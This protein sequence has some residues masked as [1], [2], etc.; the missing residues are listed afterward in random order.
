MSLKVI[1]RAVS[2]VVLGVILVGPVRSFAATATTV[3]AHPATDI[4]ITEV[5]TSSLTNAGEE[6][7]ELYNNTTQDIDLAD[8]AHAGKDA[9]KLQYFSSSKLGTILGN[10]N[11]ASPFRTIALTGVVPAHDYYVL[12]GGTYQPG[13]IVPD[14]SY[15]ATLADDGGA[16]QLIDSSTSGTTTTI[17]IHSQIAWSN[18]KSLVANPLL[19]SV[20]G[21]GTSLQRLPNSDSEYVNTDGTL[22]SFTADSRISPENAWTPPAPVT[23]PDSE[24]VATDDT[25]PPAAGPVTTTAPTVPNNQ[26]LPA[27]IVTE[28]LPN[29]ASPQSDD[30]N[31]YFE[32]FNPGDTAFDLKGYTLETGTTTLHQFTFTEDTLLEPHSF[33]AFFSSDTNLNLSNSGGQARLLDPSGTILSKSDSYGTALDGEAWALNELDGVWQW[34]TTPTP[35]AGNIINAPIVLAKASVVKT[36]SKSVAKVKGAS[37]TKKAS[38]KKAKS[39]KKTAKKSASGTLAANAASPSPAPI[40][41]SVL[42][43]VAALAVGYGVYEYRHDFGNR[44]HQLRTNRAARR[45]AR[46]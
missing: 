45:S 15:T 38:T 26:G 25:T 42:A 24:D 30:A 44:I 22:T 32:L 36:K 27:P 8:T 17:G 9:W 11:W 16:L 46:K 14:Q 29:P 12:A 31:E 2:A 3:Y 5:Q 7:V 20:P 33:R 43:A 39:S 28:L 10:P 4:I 37:T 41:T 1:V 34:T 35:N 6:F 18:D 23:V 19:Y 13:N 40:H 21:A